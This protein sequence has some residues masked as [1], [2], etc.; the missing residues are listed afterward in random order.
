METNETKTQ[1]LLVDDDG[2]LVDLIEMYFEDRYNL[3]VA[4]DAEQAFEKLQ[5]TSPDIILLDIM[6]PKMDG[7]QMLKELRKMD[8]YKDI[9][10]VL[11][12]AK[13]TKQDMKIGLASGANKY[14]TKPFDF[15]EL[16]EVIEACLNERTSVV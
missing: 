2:S 3:V 5:V 11:L 15:K 6:M 12:T 10:V 9:P 14:I 16:Y 8:R 7:I 1:V 4:K 13:G